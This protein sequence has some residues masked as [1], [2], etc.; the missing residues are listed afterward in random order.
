MHLTPVRKVNISA[1]SQEISRILF[2]R[3][4]VTVFKKFISCPYYEIEQYSRRPLFLGAFA[5][6]PKGT[7]SF[8]MSLSPSVR[9]SLSLR[10]EHLVFH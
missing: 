1:P 4:F 5:K 2:N 8:V 7:I 10:M 3:N 9:L 6:F